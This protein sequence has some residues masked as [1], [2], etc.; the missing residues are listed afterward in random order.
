[1]AWQYGASGKQMEDSEPVRMAWQYSASG[2]Q[3]EEAKPV[4][5]AWQF[6]ASG[7]QVEEKIRYELCVSTYF[8]AHN[9]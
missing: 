1:M 2:K 8:R 6:G 3:V 5:M 4:Q 9:Y 7:K